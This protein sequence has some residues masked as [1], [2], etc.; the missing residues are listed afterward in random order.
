MDIY[1]RTFLP[2][3]L[4]GNQYKKDEGSSGTH[5]GKNHGNTCFGENKETV[6]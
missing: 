2:G 5:G 6:V 1:A 4:Y 3:H